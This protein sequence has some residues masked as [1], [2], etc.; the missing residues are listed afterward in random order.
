MTTSDYVWGVTTDDVERTEE[1][2][3]ASDEQVPIKRSLAL[4]LESQIRTWKPDLIVVIERKGTAVLRAL[5]ESGDTPIAWPWN[6]VIS[7]KVIEEIP[8]QELT[9]KRILIFDDMMKGGVHV[10]DLLR[11]LGGKGVPVADSSR[12]R[13][14]VFAVHE[15]SSD[16]RNLEGAIVPHAWYRRGLTTADYTATR[17]SIVTM[18]QRCGSLMLDTEHLE[19]R[20]KLTGSFERFLQALRRTGRAIVFTSAASRENITVLYED[21]AIH[22]LP[23]DDFP[24]GTRS[25]DIVKK[26]RVVGRPGNEF[27][28]IP[29]SFPSILAGQEWNPQKSVAMLLGESAVGET[30]TDIGRFYGVGL[31]AALRVLRWTLKDLYAAAPHEFTLSLP[32]TADRAQDGNGYHLEHLR[33]MYP[34]VDIDYLDKWIARIEHEARSEALQLRSLKPLNVPLLTDTDIRER[35]LDMLQAISVSIDRKRIERYWEGREEP[36]HPFGLTASEI[37]R[38]GNRFG[39]EKVVTSTLFDL[40][41]DE[42]ALVTHVQT[43]EHAD[44]HKTVERTFEPDGEIVSEAVRR[45]SSQ[46][47][48]PDAII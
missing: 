37:F 34:T 15:E 25:D 48:L 32:T 5:L 30:A 38:I 4:F 9:S 11:V 21:D 29:I 33:V 41:I 27:A 26:C 45:Y 3:L 2:Y 44:G 43:V 36:K 13:V 40:L 47:G 22:R 28:L 46:W 17:T 18:L 24:L 19:V 16:G 1:V 23:I 42:A 14:A 12:V 8:A 7:S 20:V 10:G 39:W 31:R 6:K 35:A